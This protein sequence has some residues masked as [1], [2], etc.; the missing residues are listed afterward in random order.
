MQSRGIFQWNEYYPSEEAFR[1][2]IKREEL[3]LLTTDKRVIGCIVISTLMDDIYKTIPWKV[4]TGLNFYIHRLAVHPDFQSQ[5]YAQQ[6]MS[7]AEKTAREGG[8]LSVRLDTF[9]LNSRNQ[10]FYEA[11]GYQRNGEV[12]FPKQSDAPFYCYE[13]DLR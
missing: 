7:Y 5:G 8:A 1:E 2:D 6:M 3:Y 13:L 10:R 4:P 9:S 11:R 12:Y